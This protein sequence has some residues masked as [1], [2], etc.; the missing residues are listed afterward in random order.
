MMKLFWWGREDYKVFYSPQ[1][2]R[3][4][5]KNGLILP[6]FNLVNQCILLGLLKEKALLTEPE[7]TQRELNQ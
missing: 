5:Q 3:Q 7:R 6:K 4:G 1:I 2:R